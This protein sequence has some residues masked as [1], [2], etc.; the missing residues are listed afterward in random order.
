MKNVEILSREGMKF[1]VVSTSEIEVLPESGPRYKPMMPL[2][3]IHEE[4]LQLL[5]LVVRV[6]ESAGAGQ[7]WV[8]KF[9]ASATKA[10]R[11]HL[12]TE[13]S[14]HITFYNLNPKMEA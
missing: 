12:I 5:S 3:L 1:R 7:E 10:G 9:V 13:I 11:D 14:K 4:S 6:L 8:N 2:E